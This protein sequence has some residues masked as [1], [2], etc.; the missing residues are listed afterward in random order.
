MF[1][2]VTIGQL[3]MRAAFLSLLLVLGAC[4]EFPSLDNRISTTAR[5]APYPRLTNIDP[6][7]AQA[8]IPVPATNAVAQDV[9]ARI[10]RLT[11]RANA[12]RGPIIE[13]ATLAQMQ[14]G[15]DRS[16]LR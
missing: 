9:N 11:Q 15:V 6:L 5:D 10:A 13:P 7:L 1:A 4:A 16:A 3:H 12:L 8:S 2:V 14:R